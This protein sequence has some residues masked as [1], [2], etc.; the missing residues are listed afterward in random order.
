MKQISEDEFKALETKHGR[1][2]KI[3][4]HA[5]DVVLRK[6]TKAEFKAGFQKNA[7]NLK[8]EVNLDAVERMAKDLCVFPTIGE[9]DAM[10]EDS[11]GILLLCLDPIV[12]LSGMVQRDTQGKA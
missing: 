9:L 4:T 1:V 7:F 11:P 10:I 2:Q 12:T 8:L 6:P 5:G 3:E